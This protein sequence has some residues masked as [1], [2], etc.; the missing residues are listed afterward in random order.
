MSS[1]LR[2]PIDR[3]S[4]ID[5]R[6]EYNPDYLLQGGT[7]RRSYEDRRIHDERRGDWNGISE[8]SSVWRELF[9]P[10]RYV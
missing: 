9:E 1:S 5:R 8:W 4:G 6:L 7:E 3:R 10:E 2:L